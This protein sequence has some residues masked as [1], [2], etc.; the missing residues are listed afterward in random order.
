M[1]NFDPKI[2][3]R[4][5]VR[6]DLDINYSKRCVGLAFLS[7]VIENNLKYLYIP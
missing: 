4:E 3:K 2:S 7:N 1:L 6:Y 5:S